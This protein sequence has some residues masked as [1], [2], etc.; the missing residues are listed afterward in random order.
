M[1]V[2]VDTH[3]LIWMLEGDIRLSPR[4]RRI[5]SDP[6]N[7]VYVSVLSF[8]EIAIKT[9]NGKLSISKSLN[10]VINEVSS[11]SSVILGVDPM[12]T[13]AVSALPFHHR[14]PFDRMLI[15]QA[16][17]EFLDLMTSDS[18]FSAYGINLV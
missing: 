17:I 16:Q 6:A 14:D 8:W 2:L 13:L 5:L 9:S 7:Q 3:V 4:R 12:H 15:A 18:A 1:N 11:S 10:E